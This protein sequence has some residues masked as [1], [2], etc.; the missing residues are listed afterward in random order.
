MFL[1]AKKLRLAL[2]KAFLTG[3]LSVTYTQSGAVC[4]DFTPIVEA[5]AAIV[6]GRWGRTY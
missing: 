4:T 1:L 3:V 2:G 6:P 5:L